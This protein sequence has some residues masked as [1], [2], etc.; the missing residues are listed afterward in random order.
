MLVLLLR[1]RYQGVK[2]KH[3]AGKEM[4]GDITLKLTQDEALVLFEFFARFQE[5]DKFEMKNAAEYLAFSSVAGQ[6]ERTLV[7][8]FD[9]N[10]VQLLEQAQKRLS[11]GYEGEVPGAPGVVTTYE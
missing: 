8:P 5:T 1:S 11:D 7:A 4:T 10:Y 9:P 6:I 3:T 2:Y